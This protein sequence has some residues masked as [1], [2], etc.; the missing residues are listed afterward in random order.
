MIVMCVWRH[1]VAVWTKTVGI[2]LL[3]YN[4]IIIMFFWPDLWS[5]DGRI[6]VS[7]TNSSDEITVAWVEAGFDIDG[8]DAIESVIT[9]QV[10]CIFQHAIIISYVIMYS[11]LISQL[12]Y[13][14]SRCYRLLYTWNVTVGK[15]LPSGFGILK[16]CVLIVSIYLCANVQEW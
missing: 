11:Y 5:S 9:F 14:N 7:S 1:S 6:V 13:G 3:L 12:V 10:V 2:L 16:A 8:L 4:I 15:N